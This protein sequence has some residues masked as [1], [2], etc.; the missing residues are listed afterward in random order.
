MPAAQ[1][2]KELHALCYEH[3]T[4]MNPTYIPLKVRRKSV[5]TLVYACA[6]P[7]CL[8]HYNGMHGYFISTQK[9]DKILRDM[10]PRVGCPY[11]GLL[12]YLA[13]VKPQQRSFR[14]WRCP[15]CKASRTNEES[16]QR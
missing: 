16:A 2:S 7:G 12:M 3:H 1:P 5:Q 13:E 8:V 14:L 9:R 15:V 4:K 10:V 11:D 6:E